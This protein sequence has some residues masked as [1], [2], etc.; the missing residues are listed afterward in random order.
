[1]NLLKCS[2]LIISLSSFNAHAYFIDYLKVQ[3][4]GEIGFLSIGMGKRFGDVYSL[5]IF[6]GFV[7]ESIGGNEIE[8]I[9]I[10]NI[11]DIVD[12]SIFNKNMIFYFGLNLYHVTGLDYQSSRHSSYPETYYRLGSIRGLLSFGLDFNLNATHGFYLESGLNDIILT[13]YLNN[14]DDVDLSKYVSHGIGYKNIF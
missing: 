2:L 8:S 6:N 4:A 1:M 3:Y 7:P 11:F 14:P 10:K 9:A 13:N 5:E 12:F